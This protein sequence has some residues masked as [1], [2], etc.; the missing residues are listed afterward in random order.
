MARVAVNSRKW[1]AK[2]QAILSVAITMF[3]ERGVD[4]VSM[5]DVGAACD[6]NIATLYHYF[7][8]KDDLY[9]QSL[10]SAFGTITDRISE[11]AALPGTPAD[12]LYA[13]L[14]ALTNFFFEN[15]AMIRLL[16]R[17]ILL[18][19]QPAYSRAFPDKL[20]SAEFQVVEILEEL[21]PPIIARV[22]A[23]RLGEMLW[24]ITWAI[25][26]NAPAH[27]AIMAGKRSNIRKKEI[28]RELWE[29]YIRI[30]DLDPADDRRPA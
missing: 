27:V 14:L 30:L 8:S 23:R 24:D 29:I 12:K 17:E 22:S 28:N 25:I 15:N 11:I 26:R 21:K 5:R 19:N 1:L 13:L 18:F 4:K 2:R 16:E 9:H 10:L 6:L 3:A 7:E 20:R